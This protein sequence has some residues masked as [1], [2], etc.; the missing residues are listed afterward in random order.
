MTHYKGQCYAWDVVNEAL[1]SDGSF[2]ES[3]FFKT[4]G[5]SYIK[6]AF[7]TAAATDPDVKLYYNDF[8][9]ENPGPK[10]TGALNIVKS[11]KAS[12]TKIDGVG[13]Q[14]HFIVGSTPSKAVQI[15]NLESFT[16][17]GV[18]VAYTEL[19]IR[20]T[21]PSTAALDAQ[22]T[23]DYENTVA[24]CVQVTNCIGVT[25]WDFSDKYS[26]VP[27][28]FPGT[29]SALPF[30]ENLVRKSAYFGIHDEHLQKWN[31]LSSNQ[32]DGFWTAI[33][34]SWRRKE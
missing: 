21:L 17:L 4:M 19:D 34:N 23:T 8:S 30:D 16:A 7:D 15:K 12:G 11:L 3:V 2:R 5:E 28:T 6:I 22:Q 33:I 1:E 14:A 18:E 31:K 26:W 20:M 24:A 29:G 32:S 13:L 27:S 25:V 10:A 9:I